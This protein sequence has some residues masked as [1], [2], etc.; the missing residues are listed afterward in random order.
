MPSTTF[1]TLAD[2]KARV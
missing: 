2:S 1:S